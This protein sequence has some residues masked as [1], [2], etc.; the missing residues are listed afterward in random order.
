VSDPTQNSASRILV[1]RFGAAQGVRGEVRVKSFTADPLAL[2]SY[3]GLTDQAGTRSFVIEAARAVKDDMIVVRLAGLRDRNGAEALTNTDIYIAR[4]ALPPPDDDEFYVA[5]LVGL[6]VE[7]ADGSLFG[8]VRTVLNFGAGDIIE[9]EPPAGVGETKLLPFT[10]AA[11]P[12]VDVR[13]GRI[14]VA[15]PDEIEVK[16]EDT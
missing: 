4:D 9:V 11:V 3:K 6:R 7:L 16:G 14:V 13:G 12:V 1:G 8:K 15:P 10:A 2:A 5:D